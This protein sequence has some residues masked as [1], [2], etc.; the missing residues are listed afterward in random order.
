MFA[1]YLQLFKTTKWGANSILF[2]PDTFSSQPRRHEARPIQNLLIVANGT[3][4]PCAAALPATRAHARS[5]RL[6]ISNMEGRLAHKF[7][8]S[9]QRR[10]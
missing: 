8:P 9:A 1:N 10:I 7:G 6:R 5:T 2:Q 3:S 4:P